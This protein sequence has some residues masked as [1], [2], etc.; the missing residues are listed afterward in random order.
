LTSDQ[1]V[2]NTEATVK[3]NSTEIDNYNAFNT[4][5]YRFTAPKDGI[6]K[7]DGK[8]IFGGNGGVNTT[9]STYLYVNGIQ[10]SLLLSGRIIVDNDHPTFSF[11]YNELI[12]LNKDDYIELRFKRTPVTNDYKLRSGSAN[13]TLNIQQIQ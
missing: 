9:I 4:S 2:S 5:N 10:K 12:K 7:L 13:S 11:T 6:Y 1:D 8:F 3:F